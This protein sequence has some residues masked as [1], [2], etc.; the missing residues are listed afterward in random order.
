MRFLKRS[1]SASSSLALTAI[2]FS[3]TLRDA[4]ERCDATLFLSRRCRYFCSAEALEGLEWD[5]RA[6]FVGGASLSILVGPVGSTRISSLL[7]VSEPTDVGRVV[8]VAVPEG[9]ASFP[10][11]LLLSAM[12]VA[13]SL[14]S[15]GPASSCSYKTKQNNRF[16]FNGK[17]WFK[18][19]LWKRLTVKTYCH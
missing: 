18:F 3:R 4:R 6:L 14:K 5:V 16:S 17:Y 1:L 19:G 2:L 12:K 10:K 7:A 9:S 8:M 13:T 15:D 11:G